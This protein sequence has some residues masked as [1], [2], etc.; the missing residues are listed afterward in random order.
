[1]NDLRDSV[2]QE[3]FPVQE[4]DGKRNSEQTNKHSGSYNEL[5]PISG[6]KICEFRQSNKLPLVVL[7]K[8]TSSIAPICKT[9]AIHDT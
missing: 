8:R 5:L 9:N 2:L 7:G 1:M 6:K 3:P 4:E